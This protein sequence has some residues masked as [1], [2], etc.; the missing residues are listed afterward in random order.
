MDNLLTVALEAHHAERNHHR[1]YVATVGR[2]L[3]GDWT[4][5]VHYGRVGQGGQEM[6]YAAPEP[7]EVQAILRDRLRR[8]LSAPRRIGCAYRLAAFSAAPG[9]DA[10]LWLPGEVMAAFFQ[11]A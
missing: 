11:T 6:R 4:V 1:S 9:F 7:Q 10:A 8:R 2:D 3:F 5:T